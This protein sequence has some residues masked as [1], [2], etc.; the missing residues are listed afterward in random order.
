M[1][2][3]GERQS[4]R[5]VILAGGLIVLLSMGTRQ[6]FGLFLAPASESLGFGR[7]SFSLAVAVQNILC[8]Y[9]RACHR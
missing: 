4:A 3:A 5:R 7:E 1:S 6:S 2:S 8:R 9:E